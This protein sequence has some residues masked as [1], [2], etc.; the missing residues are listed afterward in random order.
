MTIKPRDIGTF[1]VESRSR[2]GEWHLVSL[3]VD[4]YYGC[5]CEGFTFSTPF[6]TCSHIR[7]VMRRLY[8]HKLKM[9]VGF[10]R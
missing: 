7:E 6:G 10:K 9:I 3:I 2:P 4:E 8:L 1:L 5:S